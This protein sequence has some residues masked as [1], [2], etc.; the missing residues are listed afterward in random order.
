MEFNHQQ[1]ETLLINALDQAIVLLD[2]RGRIQHAN[3]VACKSLG[4]SLDA[5]LHQQLLEHFALDKQENDTKGICLQSIDN[6]TL[7]TGFVCA[8]NVRK[9]NLP[10]EDG[11]NDKAVLWCPTTSDVFSIDQSTGLPDRKMLM[12]Q[13]TALLSSSFNN[14]HTLVKLQIARKDA[15]RLEEVDQEQRESLMTDLA[16]ILSPYIRQRDLLARGDVDYFVLLL[17]GCD[18]D[19]AK[20]ITLKLISEIQS[21]H[22]DY[23]DTHLPEWRICS[24]IIPLISGNTSEETCE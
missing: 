10:R 23:P 9:I 8:K 20:N 11:Q 1:R 24:G 14:P 3:P 2:S 13:L 18:L 5:L 19:H 17:R 7:R 15:S 21:Y 16:K 22:E 6:G 4:Y 12:K